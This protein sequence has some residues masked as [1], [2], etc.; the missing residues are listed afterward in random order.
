MTAITPTGEGPTV[1]LHI[2]E[3]KTG[4]THFQ[5]ILWLNRA[6]LSGA[7]VQ[8]AGHSSSDQYRAMQ[9]L[10]NLPPDPEDPDGPWRGEWEVL[11]A[12]ARQ[13]RRL[14]LISQ[15]S[16]VAA[17]PGQVRRAVRSLG[18][19]V[20]IV[21][22]V[23]DFASLL[24]AE[25]QELVKHRQTRSWR[26]W[27]ADVRAAE[28]APGERSR[29]PF[30]RV[31]DTVAVLRTWASVVPA[32]HIHVVTMPR[33]TS[34]P[35][36]LWSRLAGLLGVADLEVEIDVRRN[37]SLGF[38]ESE[39]LRRLNPEV[40]EEIPNW[41]YASEVRQVLAH[42]SLAAR[43]ISRKP[44]LPPRVAAWA[45]R[46][47]EA[48]IEFLAASDFDIVGDLDELRGLERP[49]GVVMEPASAGE[50]LDVAVHS[51]A[52]LLERGHQ[53]VVEPQQR[54]DVLGADRS[55]TGIA[56]RVIRSSPRVK[57]TI[58]RV[59]AQRG[60]NWLRVFAWRLHENLS[61]R[62]SRLAGRG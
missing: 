42:E 43:P 34:D 35:E 8:L 17:N 29:H 14:A 22:T 11:A 33:R 5:E 7:G 24:P 28:P 13:A 6:A 58:R 57:R 45:R 3:P 4:T 56:M 60:A 12:Q 61:A 15:E 49:A 32:D 2:G 52:F 21:L 41:F 44:L 36:V 51:L 23:R 48:T 20:H 31:H 50:Q 19:D 16:I 46:R 38:P 27:L 26:D 30:W 9:D 47:G 25:W 62:Q 55:A 59:T 39:F 1:V 53:R 37:T 10:R 40:A 18:D 54:R